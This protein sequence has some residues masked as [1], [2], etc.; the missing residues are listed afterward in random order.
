MRGRRL[1][2]P[3]LLVT[4]ALAIPLL[5]WTSIKF[6]PAWRSLIAYVVLMGIALVLLRLA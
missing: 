3:T 5:Y 4:L 6:P 2:A 1:G